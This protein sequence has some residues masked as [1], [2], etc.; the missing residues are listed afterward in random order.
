MIEVKITCDAKG[1]KNKSNDNPPYSTDIYRFAGSFKHNGQCSFDPR[2][3][4][5][6]EICPDCEEKFRKYIAKFFKETKRR[7]K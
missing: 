7:Q 5:R 6:K 4:I 2:T 3:T 1:C